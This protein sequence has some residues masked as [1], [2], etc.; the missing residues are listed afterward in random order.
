[1][2]DV[3]CKM[4]NLSVTTFKSS[5]SVVQKIPKKTIAKLVF[6]LNGM[7]VQSY[8]GINKSKTTETD[9]KNEKLYYDKISGQEFLFF[10]VD[11]YNGKKQR[12]ANKLLKKW[13]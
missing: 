2:K 9:F 1:M 13:R 10:E 7:K 4:P 8:F 12:I 5:L 6:N 3:L 11:L